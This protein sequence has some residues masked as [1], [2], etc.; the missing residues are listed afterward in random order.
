MIV[1]IDKL[2]HD[3]RGITR[4][5]DK[6]TF[7]DDV[8]PGEVVDI[9]LYKEMKK[10]NEAKLKS[11]INASSNRIKPLCKYADKC[12]GCTIGYINY[13]MQLRYKREIVIDIINK[14][15]GIQI[16]PDIISNYNDYGYR[17]KISLKIYNGKLALMEEE[18]HN[19]VNID[20]CMLVNDKIN[21][22]IKILNNIDLS[23]ISD[24]VIKGNTEIMVI[25]NG[26]ID[27]NTLIKELSLRVNSIILNNK[28]I[29]GNEYINIKVKNYTYVIY[30]YSFFQ[31]NTDMIEKL[32]NK[33][34][35]YAG[36]GD[37]FLDLYCGAGTIGIYLSHNFNRVRGIE[38]NSDAVISANINKK[39]NGINNISFECKKVS[40]ISKINE[41]VVV[42]DPP[43]SGL[44]KV[45]TQK[46]L[47]SSSKK[48]VYVSCN[49]ITLA[50]DIN[51]LKD[52]YE[53]IDI[54]L[55][56]MFPNTKHV[57]SVILLQ[58]KD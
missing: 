40:D 8:L 4:V 29:Y 28:V 58:R 17:N 27:Q 2:S 3:F 1:K 52:K 46:L 34:L 54:T 11:I 6:I 50:R 18:S 22:V 36:K 12:G 20:S 30:P 55:F 38:I 21:D 49:P 57:E 14:Y 31:V 13:E 43:R 56:D 16:N 51:L 45:S 33:V 19:F 25:I 44:D 24:V 32:Y 35:E 42:V 23:G 10:Y 7:V 37:S 26:N 41:E 39:I 48:I 5:G 15:A 47:K 53:L 9:S